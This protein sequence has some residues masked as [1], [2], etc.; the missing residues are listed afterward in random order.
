MV[1]LGYN[2]DTG[3]LYLT[4]KHVIYDLNIRRHI[5]QV[6]GNS[7]TGKTLLINLI[8]DFNNAFLN[9]D[10]NIKVFSNKF[11]INDL[12]FSN[13]LVIIDKSDILITPELSE[14]INTDIKN[15][16]LIFGRGGLGFALSP[17][18][19]GEF[20]LNKDTKTISIYY[21]FSK[22]YIKG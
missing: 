10:S 8:K 1:N 20:I 14:Y 2:F 16:Y 12:D 4:S 21:E 15:I 17:N 13:K 5:T 7:G 18:Y 19:Y 9:S 11:S 6:I 3:H 22:S